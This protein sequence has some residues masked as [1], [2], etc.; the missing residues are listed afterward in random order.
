MASTG[1]KTIECTSSPVG[2][3]YTLYHQ[4]LPGS[5]TFVVVSP[6]QM[7]VDNEI[8]SVERARRMYLGLFDAGW[9][10]IPF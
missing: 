9:D 7:N 5:W 3:I 2:E 8:M 6:L 10:N 1:T 4:T